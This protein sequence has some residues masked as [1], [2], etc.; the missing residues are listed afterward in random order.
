VVAH[1]IS[2]IA[3]QSSVALDQLRKD[4]EATARALATIETSSRAALAE[5]RLML[6]IL[7]K[8][9]ESRAE[10]VP[11][12]GMADLPA[13]AREASAAG[14][15]I[16][17]LLDGQRPSVVPSGLDLCGYRIVQEAL[18]NVVKHAPGAS[19]EVS[20]RWSP[21]GLDLAVSDDGH[22]P[23]LLGAPEGR[24]PPGHGLV[25]MRERVALFGGSFEAGPRINGGFG[26]RVKLPFAAASAGFGL[27]DALQRPVP[28]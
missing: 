25:G 1:A 11:S 4:P 9:D 6:A 15:V 10:L 5:M 14:V 13:L 24:V 7:R 21:G 28:A 19:A 8:R 23:G 22:G 3:V 12:P 26:V 2:L 17:L 27:A 16:H 18:T 20:V